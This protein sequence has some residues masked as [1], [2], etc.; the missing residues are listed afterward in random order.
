MTNSGAFAA[1]IASAATLLVALAYLN[2]AI[3]SLGNG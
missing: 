2:A 1:M 3:R